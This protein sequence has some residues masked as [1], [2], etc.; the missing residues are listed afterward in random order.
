VI[1]GCFESFF[2]ITPESLSTSASDGT[3]E[4]GLHIDHADLL[5]VLI[6]H[7]EVVI[8][9]ESNAMWMVECCS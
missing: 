8:L 2:T 4:T 9:I 7:D 5:I 1:E 6:G 3:N